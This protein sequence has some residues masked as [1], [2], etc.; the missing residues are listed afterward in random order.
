[1][2]FQWSFGLP[3]RV[4]GSRIRWDTSDGGSVKRW[5]DSG[6]PGGRVDGSWGRERAQAT[7]TCGESSNSSCQLRLRAART[8]L[9]IFTCLSVLLPAIAVAQN[10]PV[11]TPPVNERAPSQAS[12]AP[13]SPAKP[14]PLKPPPQPTG[15]PCDSGTTYTF[16]L[17]SLQGTDA[18]GIAQA[19]NGAF[20]EISAVAVSSAGAKGSQNQAAPGS[21]VGAPSQQSA[22]SPKQILC[23][24]QRVTNPNDGT[25]TAFAP[26]LPSILVSVVRQLD[27]PEFTSVGLDARFLVH[28]TNLDLPALVE[29]LPEPAPGFE[30]SSGDVVGQYLIL[31]PASSDLQLATK[32][33]S[34]L[35]TQAGKVKRDLLALDAQRHLLSAEGASPPDVVGLVTNINDA[36]PPAAEVAALKGL[37]RWDAAHTVSLAVLDAR[38]VVLELG[39]LF[40]GRELQALVQQQA[41]TLRPTSLAPALLGLGPQQGTLD[42]SDA[43]ERDAIYEQTKAER[44]WEQKLES[45]GASNAK[46]GNGNGNS[47]P[48]QPPTTTTTS[49][50]T[51][52]S[53]APSATPP[54]A[55]EAPAKTPAPIQVQT[56][57]S[58]QTTTPSSAQSSTGSQGAA[59]NPSGSST[60]NLVPAGTSNSTGNTAS[61]SS[62]PSGRPGDANGSAVSSSTAQS[63]QPVQPLLPGKVV[64]LFHLRQA[65]NIATVINAMMPTGSGNPSLVEP[66]SDNGNDDLLLI[67]H[68]TAGQPDNTDGI[69]RMIASMDEPRPAV[70]LQ[71]WSYEI[72]STKGTKLGDRSRRIGQANDV[73][74]VYG[75]FTT[76]VQGADVK[77]QAAMAAGMAAA[78]NYAVSQG[79]AAQAGTDR[80]EADLGA[81]DPEAA[82]LGSFFDPVFRGYLTHEFENCVRFDRYCLGYVDALAFPSHADTLT[83]A[84]LERFVVLLAAAGDNQVRGMIDAAVDSMQAGQN[85]QDLTPAE[86][87]LCFRSFRLALTALAQTRNLRQF[88]A[89]VLDFL[90]Q[91]KAAMAYSNDFEPYYFQR[92]AQKLDGYLNDLITALNRDLD[93]YVERQLQETATE[94][95]K[96]TRGRVGLANYG[97][98]QVSAISGSPANVSGAVNNYFDITRPALLKDVLA[99]LLG[100]AGGSGTSSGTGSGGSTGGGSGSSTGKSAS[101]T[102]GESTSS[103]SGDALAS[104]AKLLTPWQA[105]A[106]NALAAA[107]APPQLM[108]QVNAQTTLAVTP[109]SLDTASAAELAISLQISNPTS[110]LDASKGAP[111]SFIRQ[112]LANSVANYNVQTRIR[113]DSL[114]LFQVSSLSMDLTH[115]ETS[116]PVPVVGWT[117]EAVFGTVPWMKDHILAIPREPKTVENRSVAVVRAVVI[118]TAMDLGLSLPFRDDSI[119][120]PVTGTTKSLSALAQTSNKF[121][122]FHQQL[123]HCILEGRDDCMTSVRLS[124]VAEESY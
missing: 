74:A 35:A 16:R 81:R 88:R 75:T 73:S 71:V 116:V 54:A 37:E 91:Y 109:I 86:P 124:G 32:A 107:S 120:D 12:V 72:S 11:Q 48:A 57:T 100:G 13:K 118:P 101:S 23:V 27:R 65:S 94:L 43:I 4:V 97:E 114:R 95:T 24:Y 61:G 69:R 50:T 93:H 34:D 22:S 30:L 25:L 106:L 14:K 64:R 41:I 67:L 59:Q 6:L 5:H 7:R 51:I 8:L 92:S 60:G 89:A 21:S 108:A 68:P 85:C 77:L 78:M 79:Q 87:Q 66:L 28:L 105:V 49:N 115:A 15:A 83:N 104:A 33:G 19:L 119:E 18:D 56:T 110:T 63:Q 20:D 122:E 121:R 46:Q 3:S 123:M 117:W 29:A 36:A 45:D 1:M 112:D 26:E 40:P 10:P 113:V 47:N 44:I 2:P 102:S 9:R 39:N 111:S 70:S 31:H 17:R 90:F 96:S 38:A 52:T 80:E 99:G 98:V 58:T 42:V 84:S 53:S 103:A 82:A 76:A 55:G 62:G